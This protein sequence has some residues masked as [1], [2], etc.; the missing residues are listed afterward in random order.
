MVG[1]G[2]VVV[3]CIYLLLTPCYRSDN[4]YIDRGRYIDNRDID[5]D[6]DNRDIDRDIDNRD[7]DRSIDRYRHRVSS[8]TSIGCLAW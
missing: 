6:I 8:D 4:I 5:R 3:R 7:I 2:V 1:Y